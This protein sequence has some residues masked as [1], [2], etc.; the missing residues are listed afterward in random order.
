MTGGIEKIPE[1]TVSVEAIHKEIKTTVPEKLLN[2]CTKIL[3]E[4]HKK[5]Y[6][7]EKTGSGGKMVEEIQRRTRDQL[8]HLAKDEG[9]Q[10]EPKVIA[11]LLKKCDP[12]HIKAIPPKIERPEPTKL[13]VKPDHQQHHHH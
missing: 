6:L 11:G 8:M 4:Y 9:Y 3:Q 7:T 13:S 2:G 1:I 12:S 5:L 10:L